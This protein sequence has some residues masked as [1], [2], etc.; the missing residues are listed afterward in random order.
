MTTTEDISP[1]YAGLDSWSDEAILV[2]LV[3]GQERAIA[4]VR[5]ARREIAAAARA[6]AGRLGDDGRIVYVGAGS[7]KEA[8]R[9]RRTLAT[10][11]ASSRSTIS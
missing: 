7:S 4:A 6:I 1:R 8:P 5:R 11:P 9:S 2:A 10:S 3:E